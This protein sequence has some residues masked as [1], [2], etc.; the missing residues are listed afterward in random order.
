MSSQLLNYSLGIDASSKEFDISLG[1]LDVEQKYSTINSRKFTNT[2]GGFKKLLVWLEKNHKDKSISLRITLEA[3]GVYHERL[4]YF[5]HE[6]GY[7]V[8]VVVPSKSKHYLRSLGYKSKT[9]KIDAK[10]LSCMGAQQQLKKWHP[11]SEQMRRLK[12]ATRLREQLQ[13]QIT[14]VSNQL[15]ANK[16]AAG[17]NIEFMEL[18][19][20]HRDFMKQ[21]VKELDKRIEAILAED[22]AVVRKVKGIADSLKGVGILTVA[23]LIAETNGFEHIT[24][25][26]QLTSYSGY[27]IIENQSGSKQGKTKMSK[28]GNSHIRRAMHMPALNVVRYETGKFPALYKR[29]HQ[30]TTIKMKGYVAVQR[31]LLCLIYTL[32]KN[33]T[34]FE[35]NYG[36]EQ[37]QDNQQGETANLNIGQCR[38]EAPLS[39]VAA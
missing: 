3:T 8:S 24:S 38:A 10:G 15:H 36:D 25:Q 23:T 12:R 5:L 11:P 17:D 19:Q 2:P 33:D 35:E 29:V 26:S 14:Q 21:Q 37:V 31:K 20:A 39:G 28:Q 27:D 30:R 7:D 16:S 9:D 13:G 22:E 1:Q 34:V 32:W 4:T 18:Q 6:A